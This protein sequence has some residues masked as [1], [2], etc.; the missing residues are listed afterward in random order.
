MPAAAWLIL[1]TYDEA[2]NIAAIVAAARDVLESAMPG[3]H[4]ILVVD[5]GSPDGTGEIADRLAAEHDDVEVL[6]R[7]VREGLGPA[8]LA[9][10]ARALE[11]G[12]QF[13]LEM[14]SDFSH[15]PADLARLLAAIADADLALG[16]RYVAG[17]GV[18][19][20]GRIRRF[21]SRGGSWYARKVLGLEVRDLTGGFKCFRREVLEAIDL[22]TVRSRGYAFQVELTHRA[23]HAGFRVVELPI[24]FRDRRL[25]RSKMSWRIAGEAAWLVPQL[26]LGSHIR[27]TPPALIAARRGGRRCEVGADLRPRAR[28]G[29]RRHAGHARRMERPSR[30]GRRAL[31][32]RRL[33][34]HRRAAAR[35][36]GHRDALGAGPER[37]RSSGSAS[38][39]D[40][41]QV[42]H[43]LGRNSLVLALHAMACVAG[44]I[45]GSSLPLEA[46]RRSGA[47]RWIHEKAGPLAI[48]FVIGATAFSLVT[49]AFVLGGGTASLA[50]K[51][52]IGPGLLLIG[53]LPHALPELVA[54]FLP[55]AAW[56]IAS[57]QKD[58]HE[59]LAATVVTVLLGVPV[60][61]ASAFVEVY[62]SPGLLRSLAG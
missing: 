32:R 33:R 7:T 2:E 13:I 46:Q 24:V 51:L 55:L 39:P 26:R 31:A 50:A 23:I 59:L 37:A 40:L 27:P 12:A 28:P 29:P 45:A 14:D 17:G 18:T 25:G 54:L 52:D 56:M 38:R 1:P 42:V 49:Q 47:W 3:E 16:S 44:F 20:W 10:F 22:P 35:R 21:V 58:W 48:A 11:G 60:L 6:H 19:D 30:P 62:V 53:L 43:V 5:D 4:R 8:Y 36:L 15:D 41:G 57:R 61:V 34:D 9:G